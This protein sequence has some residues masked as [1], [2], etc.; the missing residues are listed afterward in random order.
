MG[1]APGAV[2][3]ARTATPPAYPMYHPVN[4][5][6]PPTA[7]T[8]DGMSRGV[9][10][11]SNTA[12]AATRGGILSAPNSVTARPLENLPQRH[13]RMVTAQQ[14]PHYAAYDSH[15]MPAAAPGAVDAAATTEAGTGRGGANPMSRGA[16][17][18]HAV[19]GGNGTPSE[20][21]PKSIEPTPPPSTTTDPPATARAP[22][23]A[24]HRRPSSQPG[25]LGFDAANAARAVQ[26]SHAPTASTG[27]AGIKGFQPQ[28]LHRSALRAILHCNTREPTIPL[29]PVSWKPDYIL[30]TSGGAPASGTGGG[31]ANGGLSATVCE[32]IGAPACEWSAYGE[33]GMNLWMFIYCVSPVVTTS[34]YVAAAATRECGTAAAKDKKASDARESKR[35]QHTTASPVTK[36]DSVREAVTPATLTDAAAAGSSSGKGLPPPRAAPTSS[37]CT[38]SSSSSVTSSSA[39]PAADSNDG[40]MALGRVGGGA[41]SSSAAAADGIPQHSASSASSASISNSPNNGAAGAV[42]PT[43]TI[44]MASHGGQFFYFIRDLWQA[45]DMPYGVQIP[46]K[47]SVFHPARRQGPPQALP[48]DHASLVFYTPVLSGFHIIASSPSSSS[49][50]DGVAAKRQHFRWFE[51]EKPEDRLPLYDQIKQLTSQTQFAPLNDLR[52]IDVDPR[53]WFAILWQP[54]LCKQHTPQNSCGSFLVFYLLN[55]PT[56][57][58]RRDDHHDEENPGERHEH[59]DQPRINPPAPPAAK[60]FNDFGIAFR[61]V[62]GIALAAS[63]ST[64]APEATTL[65][66]HSGPAVPS[67]AQSTTT[68]SSD[69]HHQPPDPSAAA[70]DVASMLR[71]D[72][73]YIEEVAAA[74]GCRPGDIAAILGGDRPPSNSMFHSIAGHHGENIDEAASVPFA[75]ASEPPHSRGHNGVDECWPSDAADTTT[76]RS[77]F[78][79]LMFAVHDDVAKPPPPST[80]DGQPSSGSRKTSESSTTGGDATAPRSSSAPVVV[81][82]GSLRIPVCGI[83]PLRTRTD[84]WFAP[85]NQPASNPTTHVGPLF[86]IAAAMELMAIEEEVGTRLRG[87]AEGEARK[88]GASGATA[89]RE[90]PAK[91]VKSIVAPLFVPTVLQD[92]GFVMRQDRGLRAFWDTYISDVAPG[93][94]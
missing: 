17:R 5:P 53:S 78:G 94:A 23:A 34:T 51:T 32:W 77:F 14:Q 84:V 2:A 61:A 81:S 75:A 55:P 24:S 90:S 54:I 76:G 82:H 4:S 70:D 71:C 3:D 59:A 87:V 47:G 6:P 20:V 28:Q 44:M 89:T 92:F 60:S 11:P 52:N 79:P 18:G 16:R 56:A 21:E 29:P 65:I 15:Q 27:S 10:T 1:F 62:D 73:K 8:H 63:D 50:S 74:Y 36:T 26:L 31:G 67:S 13:H 37:A 72:A 33:L 58:R 91:G 22:A 66:V 7:A 41:S 64:N 40:M 88:G 30:Y 57:S 12:A 93:C 43:T 69:H 19:R 9:A 39:L 38:T 42:I 83:V 49:R 68:T 25:Q 46:L 35:K 86:L 85:C 48:V 80:G 45:F